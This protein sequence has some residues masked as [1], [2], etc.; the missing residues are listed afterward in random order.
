MWACHY[1]HLDIVKILIDNGADVNDK[2]KV[3]SDS[4]LFY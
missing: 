2:D 1:D 4:L 3:S